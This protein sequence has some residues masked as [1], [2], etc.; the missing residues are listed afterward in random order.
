MNDGLINII[1]LGL[2]G[3][4]FVAAILLGVPREYDRKK[5]DAHIAVLVTV[6]LILVLSSFVKLLNEVF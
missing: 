3:V 5:D 6:G 4:F 1:L 2:Y